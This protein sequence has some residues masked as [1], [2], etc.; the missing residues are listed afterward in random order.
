MMRVVKQWNRLPRKVV[1]V[2]PLGTLKARFGQGSGQVADVPGPCRVLEWMGV[3]G[4]PLK[5]QPSPFCG[6]MI[7][8]FLIE[9][10][11][12]SAQLKQITAAATTCKEKKGVWEPKEIRMQEFQ[13][14]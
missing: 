4:H 14:F 5:A 1:G 3:S 11:V 10:K 2:P 9:V 7:H 8:N 13:A 12:M 6:S